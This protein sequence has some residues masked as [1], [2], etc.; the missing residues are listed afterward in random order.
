M[1]KENLTSQYQQTALTLAASRGYSEA[2][3]LLLEAGANINAKDAVSIWLISPAHGS[4]CHLHFMARQWG[5]TALDWAITSRH[6]AVAERLRQKVETPGTRLSSIRLQAHGY[7]VLCILL[8]CLVSSCRQWATKT[9]A[10]T[11]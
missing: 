9:I 10:P 7:L 2:V 4:Y 11:P 1:S 8:S 5:S 3:S 6:K